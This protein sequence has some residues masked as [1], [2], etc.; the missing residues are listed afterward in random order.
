MMPSADLRSR[1]LAAVSREPAPARPQ[2]RRRNAVLL[3][4]AFVVPT[5]VFLAFGGLRQAARPSELVVETAAGAAFIALVV[6]ITALSRGRSMLGR[7]GSLL[8]AAAVLTPALLF[9]YKVLVSSQYP[10]LMLQAPHRPGLRCL[11]LS[12]LMAAWPVVAFTLMRRGSDPTNP[13]L[14]GAALGAVA[15]AGVWL[16]VDLWCPVA[17]VPHLL[18][19]HVLPVLLCVAAGALLGQRLIALRAFSSP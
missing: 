1:V 12:C 10:S 7:P 11:G 13:R 19:G 8:L 14:T 15:G 5:L 4:S 9:A 6:G 18:L 3:G 2:V 16:L 17:Y